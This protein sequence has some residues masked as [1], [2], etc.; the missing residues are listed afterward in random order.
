[1]PGFKPEISS[2]NLFNEFV[3]A[4]LNKPDGITIHL[5]EINP[6]L[7]TVFSINDIAETERQNRTAFTSGNQLA[8]YFLLIDGS[9]DNGSVLALSYKNTSI[10]LFGDPFK[11]FSIGSSE[12]DKSKA[13]AM[14]MEHEFGHLIGLVDMGCFMVDDHLDPEHNNHCINSHCLMHHTFE[15]QTRLFEKTLTEI[16]VFDSYCLNDLRAN[17]GK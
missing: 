15:T 8:C 13:M 5:K 9:Y 16:P 3:K 10:C 14:L 4:R 2:I 17:G 1:M 12:D 7:K 11:Y 6:T